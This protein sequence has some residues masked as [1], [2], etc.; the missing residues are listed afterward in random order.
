MPAD[1]TWVNGPEE[2]EGSDPRTMWRTTTL[3]VKVTENGG[4]QLE[5]RPTAEILDIG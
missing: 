5:S 1:A 4:R 3:T 2:W